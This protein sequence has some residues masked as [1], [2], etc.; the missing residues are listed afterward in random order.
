MSKRVLEILKSK[1][2]DD[3]YET[4][5]Q[6]GDDTAVVN[7]E[8]WREIARFL[9]DDPQCAMNMFVDLTAVDYLGR[10]T[11]RFEV[12]LHLRSMERNHRIRL[13]ARIGDED[14]N[15]ADIDSL[16]PVWK[17]ANWFERECF[18]M[19]GVNFKGHPDLRRILMYPEFVGYPLRK[20]YPADK[21]QPLVELRNVPDKL[22]PFGIDEGMPFGRQTH[23]YPRGEETN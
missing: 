15:G 11:P 21:T 14:A 16:V 17:G 10:Q 23:D 13:K 6:F 7:P 3:I 12:V 19:F 1:F 2:G 8:K 20:D 22:P 18:D 9:R 4:H 5:S